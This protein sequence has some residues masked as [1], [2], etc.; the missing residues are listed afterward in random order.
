VNIIK[1]KKPFA[2]VFLQKRIKLIVLIEIS[3]QKKATVL[4]AGRMPGE[5]TKVYTG[6]SPLS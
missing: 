4:L 1:Y 6:D 3:I 5:G 2:V